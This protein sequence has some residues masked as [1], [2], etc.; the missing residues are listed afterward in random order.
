MQP[1]SGFL[2][3][4]L[5]AIYDS[6]LEINDLNG[7]KW[8]IILNEKTLIRPSAN[9]TKGEMIKIIGSKKDVNNFDALEIRPWMGQGMMNGSGVGRSSGMMNNGGGRGIMNGN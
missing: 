1:N 3:G 5:S 8:N 6:K 4:T 2:S 7:Q 9:I